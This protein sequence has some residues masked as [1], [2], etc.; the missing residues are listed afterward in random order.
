MRSNRNFAAASW[1]D[2]NPAFRRGY[3]WPPESLPKRATRTETPPADL[4][5]LS[6][7]VL[8]DWRRDRNH[9][10]S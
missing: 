3:R 10:P 8:T 2:E 7:A 5:R 6:T 9:S 1:P 4:T